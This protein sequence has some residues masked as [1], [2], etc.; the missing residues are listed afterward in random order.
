MHTLYHDPAMEMTV[1]ELREDLAQPLG[2][3]R[4]AQLL[5]EE[6]YRAKIPPAWLRAVDALTTVD[7]E[8]ASL[9]DEA[10]LPPDVRKRVNSA[11]KALADR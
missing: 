10:L 1:G 8:L 2:W 6:P 9:S 3:R 4:I 5:A 7:Q 11:L